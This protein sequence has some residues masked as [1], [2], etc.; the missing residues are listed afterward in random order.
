MG[1]GS[2]PAVLP[3]QTVAT[4]LGRFI[5]RWSAPLVVCNRRFIVRAL[6]LCGLGVLGQ[7]AISGQVLARPGWAGSGVAPEPWWRSAVIYR[8]DPTR[9]QDSDGDGTGDLPG[10][11]QRL[12]YLQSLG[13]DAI[14]LDRVP[15]RG[16]AAATA[17]RENNDAGLDDLVRSAS[18]HHMRV[19]VAIS[20]E[21][22]KVGQPILQKAVHDWLSLGVAGV[23]LPKPPLAPSAD[24]SSAETRYV[25]LRD[26]LRGVLRAMPGERLLLAD[27]APGA[28]GASSPTGRGSGRG[29]TTVLLTTSAV[30]PAEPP[31]AVAL[32]SSLVSLPSHDA[33]G[34]V[35]LLRFAGRP[36]TGSADAVAEAALLLGSRGAVILNFGDEIGLNTSAPVSSGTSSPLP[37]MQW[38]PGN[39]QRPA[40]APIERR[41]VSPIAEYGAYHP[42]IHPPPTV[43]TGSAPAAPRAT[44]D[45]DI[46]A[47]LPDPDTLPGFT[48][49]K[50]PVS[51][52]QGER[53]N[54]AS[55]ERD[56]HS[57]L[58]AF[59]Q[60]IALHHGNP[61]VRSGGEVVIPTSEAST[62]VWLRRRPA[63][64]ATGSDVLGAVNLGDHAVTLNLDGPLAGAGMHPG[65]LRALFTYA[66]APL[67]GETTTSLRLPPHSVYIGEWTYTGYSAR[68]SHGR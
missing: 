55:E 14:L 27:P 29:E 26:A 20:P 2:D 39:T 60:L 59:R 21:L 16:F 12:D 11:S 25:A 41:P 31:D 47:A 44:I 63:G 40:P 51:P 3:S 56:P 32:R 48:T 46:P 9:F 35:S 33:P 4:R 23:W 58:A 8:L 42:Y 6:F 57:T 28:S 45:G 37:L 49:G 1:S 34:S 19:L 50:L 24:A 62:V 18:N 7:G 68:R 13:V 17:S 36:R 52:T 22:Q 67:T 65:S 66:A 61:A 30:L 10:V 38:T 43:L 64:D 5:P 53:L 15:E 54:V